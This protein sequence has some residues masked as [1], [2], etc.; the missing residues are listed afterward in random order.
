VE[1]LS[2]RCQKKNYRCLD[3]VS[4]S[5]PQWR[6]FAVKQ[7]S[8]FL[9]LDTEC[10]LLTQCESEMNVSVKKSL[11]KTVRALYNCFQ[12]I[13]GVFSG[14]RTWQRAGDFRLICLHVEIL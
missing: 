7:V 5:Q 1:E 14:T 10:V 11:V 13:N 3:F 4:S 8:I 6:F 12:G 9:I 2:T